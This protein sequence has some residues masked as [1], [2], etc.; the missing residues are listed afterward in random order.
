MKSF[1]LY[2]DVPIAGAANGTCS[3]TCPTWRNMLGSLANH[4]AVGPNSL[5]A[6]H[7]TPDKT[8]VAR[9]LQKCQRVR[10]GFS[11]SSVFLEKLARV[12]HRK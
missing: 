9:T 4:P 7:R 11:K 8:Y 2:F 6:K 3:S 1:V 10:V 5:K 12:R